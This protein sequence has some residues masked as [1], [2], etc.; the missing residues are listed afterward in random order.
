MRIVNYQLIGINF[1]ETQQKTGHTQ[2]I[3]YNFIMDKSQPITWNTLRWWLPIALALA[4]IFIQIGVANNKLDT[5]I[6]QQSNFETR[7]ET[8]QTTINSLMVD[9]ATHG[10]RITSLETEVAPLLA[11]LNSPR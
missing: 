10:V 5:V 4:A 9:D 6:A 7:I 11:T 3:L 1:K 2:K 8:Q